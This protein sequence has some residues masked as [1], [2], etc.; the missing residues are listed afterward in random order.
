MRLIISL[1]FLDVLATS[2]VAG[3]VYMTQGLDAAFMV[4]LSVFVAFSPICLVLASPFTLYLAGKKIAEAGVT[5]NNPAALKTVADVNVV[6]LPY[7]RILTCGEYYVTDLVPEGLSQAALL[8]IAASAERDAQH[9]LGRT[10]YDTAAHRALRLQGSTNF[11]E[12]AGRGVEANVTGTLVRVGHPAW[13]ESQGASV[14]ANLRTKIDQL[15]VKGKTVLLFSMNRTARGVIALKDD[16]SESAR[17]FLA[18]LQLRNIETLLLTAA[19]KKMAGRISKDFPLNHVRTNL[20]PEGKAREIQIFRAKG[21]IVAA[22]GNEF[23]DLPA[24]INADVSFFLAD[25]SLDPTELKDIHIDFEMP[26]LEKFL[27]VHSIA[28]KVV[29]V[30]KLNRRIA[31]ASWIVLVPPSVM[32]ALESSPL[33]WHPLISVAGVAI[34]SAAILANSLRTK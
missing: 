10:I 1:L 8:T 7:N 34:F 19:P 23:H 20:T 25:G 15:V 32:S 16:L 33:P 13:V 11:K 4:G 9:L 22:I 31:L 28:R 5:I 14:S 29:N 21:N 12:L 30:V 2:A 3:Y 27:T 26:S 18:T 24:L 17:K 6:A